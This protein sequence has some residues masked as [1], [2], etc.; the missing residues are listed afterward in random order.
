MWRVA[1]ASIL[2]LA[3]TGCASLV[4]SQTRQLADNLSAAIL[5]QDD[6]EIVRDGAPAY[7][8]MIDGLVA[9]DPENEDLLL[10]GAQLYGAYASAFVDDPERRRRL[11][12]RALDYGRR[13]LCARSRD[14]CESVDRPY[15]EFS[16]ALA[17]SDRAEV[18]ALYGFGAAWAGWLQAHS[19]DWGAIADI[20]KLE[21]LMGRVVALDEAVDRGGAHLYLGVL[22]TLRPAA[23]GGRPEEGRRHFE[24]AIALSE[25]RHLM[26]KVLFARHYARLVFDR[27]L[28]DRLLEEVLAADPHVP[29]LTL[30][31]TLAQDE[32]RLLLADAGDYF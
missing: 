10:T 32:A 16:I 9:G 14:L 4:R 13:A 30:S 8:I 23:M 20:P 1:A 21:A 29:L 5:D 27:A 18:P 24:R 25:G 3:L 6:V 12:S 11:S 2:L 26:A 28:H 19:E 31:N 17:A 7:L 15:D 22:A